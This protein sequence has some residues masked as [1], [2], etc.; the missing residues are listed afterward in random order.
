MEVPW[1]GSAG[2]EAGYAWG[3][4]P[5]PM[6][7]DATSAPAHASDWRLAQRALAQHP[8]AWMDLVRQHQGLVFGLLA[9]HARPEDRED[10]F[11]EV[12][13]RVHRHL[14]TFRG[15]AA[16]GTWIYRIA[17]NVIRTHWERSRRV[18]AREVLATDHL[19]P[20]DGEEEAAFDVPVEAEQEQAMA[21]GD[22]RLQ[23]QR[24]RT[25]IEGMRPLDRQVLLLRDVDGLRYDDIASR[26]GL[27]LGTL[28]SRLARARAQLAD[29]MQAGE[30]RGP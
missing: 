28:K 7:P 25:L 20:R 9:R 23:V 21:D 12:F 13:L 11:Q 17:L 29:A 22:R 18:A 24:L 4:T 6:A 2:D 1:G 10:C 27:P 16:L 15:D 5:L 19:R 26:L 30:R 14:G 8:T 3:F